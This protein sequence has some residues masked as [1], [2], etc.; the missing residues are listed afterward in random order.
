M[1]GFKNPYDPNINLSR[2]C[3]CGRHT[4]QAEHDAAVETDQLASGSEALQARV[5]ESAVMRALFPQDELRRRVLRLTDAEQRPRNRRAID[6]KHRVGMG[7]ILI[8]GFH[9][10]TPF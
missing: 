7:R 8:H 3:G 4:T 10:K 1:S 6:D 2:G 5:V 9:G